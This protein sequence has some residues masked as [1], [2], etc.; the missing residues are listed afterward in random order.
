MNWNKFKNIVQFIYYCI[1]IVLKIIELLKF[2]KKNLYSKQ[3]VNNT[4]T[5][6]FI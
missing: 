6:I 5:S 4:P 2:L 1:D 3:F